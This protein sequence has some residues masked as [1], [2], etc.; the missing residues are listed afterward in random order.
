MKASK[1]I[2]AGDR[3][4]I[5]CM[6]SVEPEGGTQRSCVLLG[7]TCG[8]I[9]IGSEKALRETE[10][11]TVKFEH[12]QIRGRISYCVRKDASYRICVDIII[13]SGRKYPRFPLDEACTAIV[14]NDAGTARLRGR[15]TDFSCNGL[16]LRLESAI[17][18]GSM[19][20]VE[21]ASLLIV[22]EARY[23]RR[24]PDSGFIAGLETTDI[25]ADTSPSKKL[26][27][28]NN[29]RLRLAE[30]VLGRPIRL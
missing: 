28:V 30:F 29:V 3:D 17:S 18:A 14:F 21:T 24:A 13:E 4:G 23:C 15:L 22:G 20:Y 1:T 5:R 27:K 12:V 7:I 6:V 10:A 9:H 26:T 8:Q 19:I 16:G 2:E 25:I 11:V